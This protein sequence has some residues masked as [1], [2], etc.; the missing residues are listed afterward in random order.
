MKK[1]LIY[2]LFP[3]PVIYDAFFLFSDYFNSF[4]VFEPVTY[5]FSSVACGCIF[6]HIGKQI[7]NEEYLSKHAQ[8]YRIFICALPITVYVA[9]ISCLGLI[10]SYFDSGFDGKDYLAVIATFSAALVALFKDRYDRFCYKPKLALSFDMEDNRLFSVEKM[11]DKTKGYML[12]VKISNIGLGWAENVMLRIESTH[13][14][15]PPMFLTWTNNFGKNNNER[16]KLNKMHLNADYYCDLAEIR[17]NKNHIFIL[18]T[19]VQPFNKS[20][21]YAPYSVT[22]KH[23]PEYFR[24]TLFADNIVPVFY[25]M[26]LNYDKWIPVNNKA[27]MKTNG[28][29]VQI[30]K[31]KR[32]NRS[33]LH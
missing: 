4:I 28:I 32:I 14:S 17:G 27:L 11:E 16:I 20:T 12:R 15:F 23:E 9:I 7:F 31:Q 6:V 33:I 13:N 19:E 22:K 25:Y 30:K 3:L 10:L 24:L 29:F 1:I 26:I 8:L 5:L 21:R 2:I 18:S